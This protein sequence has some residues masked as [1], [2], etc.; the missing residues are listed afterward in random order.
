MDWSYDVV[1]FDASRWRAYS[2][3]EPINRRLSRVIGMP[4]LRTSTFRLAY[5]RTSRFIY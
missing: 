1:S 2:F 5:Q 4:W 3:D